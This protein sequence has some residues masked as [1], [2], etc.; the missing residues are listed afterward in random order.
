VKPVYVTVDQQLVSRCRSYNLKEFVEVACK[1]GRLDL[2]EFN[3]IS[4]ETKFNKGFYE[5][6]NSGRM[7]LIHSQFDD[8]D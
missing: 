4:S 3:P 8:S 2:I 5:V 1:M 7:T 6:D